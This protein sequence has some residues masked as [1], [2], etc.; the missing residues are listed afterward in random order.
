MQEQEKRKET[1]VQ[2]PRIPKE[3]IDKLREDMERGGELIKSAGYEGTENDPYLLL[4]FAP[5]V[6]TKNV[7]VLVGADFVYAAFREMEKNG[8]FLPRVSLETVMAFL[9]EQERAEPVHEFMGSIDI[10]EATTEDFKKL[11]ELMKSVEFN[12]PSPYLYC[13]ENPAL[14]VTIEAR[15]LSFSRGAMITYEL[16]RRQF[17]AD[18]LEKGPYGR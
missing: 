3:L 6:E 1:P 18:Q 17:F 15:D 10:G 11:A 16:K 5:D 12:F 7:G 8:I 14:M 4:M 13:E 2:F 9:E